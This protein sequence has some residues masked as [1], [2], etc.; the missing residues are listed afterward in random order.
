MNMTHSDQI[1]LAI[2]TRNQR[3][4]AHKVRDWV[5]SSPEGGIV[6]MFVLVQLLCITGSLAFPEQFRY[7][8][9]ANIKVTLKAVA[10]LGIM[11]L[12]VGV[13]MIA[14]EFDLSVG[15][16]YS[17]C[18]IVCATVSNQIYESTGSAIAPF[19]GLALALAIGAVAGA[20]NARIT[21]RF[22]IPSFITTLGAMLM[23]K[24]GSLLYHGATSLQFI[25]PEPFQTLFA[26]E[27]GYLHASTLWF[28]ALA[29]GCYFLLHHHR[30]GNHFYA[31]GGNANAAI[32]IGVKPSRVKMIAFSLAGMMAA[33][34]GVVSATRVSTVQPGGGIG[35]EL[36]A[37]AACVI[38]GVALTGGRG[39]VLGIV[40][41]TALVFTINDVLL[42]LQAPGF[43]FDMFVGALIVFS[44]VMNTAI[45][46]KN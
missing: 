28:L 17:F 11:A 41:G 5:R 1:Q 36:Q 29:V 10:P 37:I 26:G 2:A 15:A 32:A 34:S 42:L 35:Y 22:A 21:M 44:V 25:P 12:G 30:L 16:V 19:V 24:G 43:Y 8:S 27:F 7:L 45:R 3:P 23:W 39:S 14:G 4:F 6:V 31:V 18:S 20:I 13:L 38:G 46:R 9:P 40:L 33:L